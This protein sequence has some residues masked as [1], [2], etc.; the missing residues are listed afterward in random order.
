[1]AYQD[2][3]GYEVDGN[4]RRIPSSPCSATDP[5][6][7]DPRFLSMAKLIVDRLT[8]G[9]V[10]REPETIAQSIAQALQ[11]QFGKGYDEGV[12]DTKDAI[13]HRFR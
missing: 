11:E 3:D 2:A 13:Q 6:P 4:G 7:T 9:M 8:P 1:M 12:R 5:N 10:E